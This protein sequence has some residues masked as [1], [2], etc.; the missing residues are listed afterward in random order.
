M[1]QIRTILSSDAEEAFK[2]LTFKAK[3]S[4]IEASLLK[5]I[6][7]KI[8]LIKINPHY[9]NPIEKSKIPQSYKEK[10]EITN[11]F[12]IELTNFWRMD[13]TLKNN[14]IEIIAFVLNIMD[15]DKYNKIYKYKKN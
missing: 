14:E 7:N 5:S 2:E 15:H 1:R 6:Q 10:Y 11:L 8:Q 3:N 4:K 9:G 12:R 13:Y